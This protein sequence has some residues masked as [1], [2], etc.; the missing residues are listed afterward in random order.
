MTLCTV[1]H[2]V[3]LSMGI[4]QARILEWAAMPSSRG[5]F[6]PSHQTQLSYDSCVEGGFFTHW[7]T[8]ETQAT[9]IGYNKYNDVP[10]KYQSSPGNNS[11]YYF[12]FPNWPSIQLGQRRTFFFFWKKKGKWKSIQLFRWTTFM[13]NLVSLSS[14]PHH[15]VWILGPLTHRSLQSPGCMYAWNSSV[16]SLELL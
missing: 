11:D 9:D 4:P 5:S 13:I 14:F 6:P 2:Q 1:A 12:I 15:S 16:F 7:T 3:P 10:E 8:W